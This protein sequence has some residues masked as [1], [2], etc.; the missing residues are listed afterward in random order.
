M[1]DPLRGRARRFALA[2]ALLLGLQ[3]SAQ[4]NEEAG[5]ATEVRDAL[6]VEA[7]GTRRVTLPD[8]W[9]AS[10]PR[11]DG[12]LVY[13]VEL[14]AA[15]LRERPAA[16]FIPRAGPA[17]RVQVNGAMLLDTV[18]AGDPS[19]AAA[20][21][22]QRLSPRAQ[23]R[24]EQQR[25]EQRAEQR[26]LAGLARGPLLLPLPIALLK[27]D[28][29]LAE[30]EVIGGPGRDA[31]LSTVW[32]GP[33][34]ELAPRHR[35]LVRHEVYG[36][37]V[38]T[39]AALVMG[40][41]ALLLAFRT[42]RGVYACFGAASLLWA[43][44]VSGPPGDDWGAWWPLASVLFHASYAWFVVLMALYALS[45][46]GVHG[47][48]A[49][50]AI[51][52]WG[53]VALLLSVALWAS[54]APVLRTLLLAGTLAIVVWLTAMLLLAAWRLR[55]LAAL[56]L[57]GAA[58]VSLA[59]GA[60]DFWIFRMQHDYGALA[61]SRY[62]IL[63]LLVVL[64]W[65]LVD[66]F[67]RSATALGDLN[68]EL[69][70][71]VASKER[72]LKRSFE[73]SREGERQQAALA[74]RDRILREMHDGLGGRLVGAMAL[75]SQV[76]RQSSAPVGGAARA[77]DEPM[78]EL[79]LTLDDCLVELR[80][81]LDSLETDR[82][83]VEALAA[84]RF[85]VE[86]TLRAAGVRLVWQIGEEAGDAMLAAGETLHVLRIV[87]EALT[88]V[89][90]HAQASVVWLRL[91]E[92]EGGGLRLVIADNGL[93]QRG[94]AGEPVGEQGSLPLFVP[95]VTAAGRGL[96]NMQRRAAALGAVL[97][98]GP[99]GEGWEVSIDLPAAGA[100]PL[101]GA[102]AAAR[103][104]TAAAEVRPEAPAA[105]LAARSAD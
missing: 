2:A 90:K 47:P 3:A 92:R 85:R 87:R 89:I 11:R 81:A 54:D 5:L 70:D 14:P 76:E 15:A 18:A 72:E 95:A 29:N 78:R 83:L 73:A 97:S 44:R 41:L 75:A 52:S 30:I 88:N 1:N 17:L 9:E 31:G 27:G 26:A 12:A 39:T 20:S 50:K 101:E 105:T 24:A 68:R 66:E 45:A 16:L 7:S 23:Q 102:S 21:A 91:F 64:A 98:S 10:A 6:T 77:T 40:V 59:V 13:R 25:A 36:T 48:R 96:A 74:E 49:R 43:W 51:A 46:A 33:L 4:P 63:L 38:I 99:Q 55:T 32:V 62:T 80:I 94:P 22:P 86:P 35:V 53:G 79:R 71:R 84:L 82:P 67:A 93:P 103:A 65:L 37:W 58:A 19:E 42:G 34:A 100:A 56:L 57:A 8:A 28:G 69:A 61:W 104:A 60:R